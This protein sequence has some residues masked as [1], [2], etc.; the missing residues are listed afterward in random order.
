[1]AGFIEFIFT[2]EFKKT[3]QKLYDKIKK[4]LKKQLRFFKSNPKH[5]S[6]KIHRLNDEWEFYIDIHYRG[7]FQMES[8]RYIFLTVDTHKIVDRYNLVNLPEK[9]LS[10]GSFL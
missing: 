9:K 4:K 10:S 6:L 3:Y 2:D 1:M 7:I 5:H 8:Q